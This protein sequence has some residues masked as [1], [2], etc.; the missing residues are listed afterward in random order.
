[1]FVGDAVLSFLPFV[2]VRI[3]VTVP[4]YVLPAQYA[5]AYVSF[6]L[7]SFHFWSLAFFFSFSSKNYISSE[8]LKKN[9]KAVELLEI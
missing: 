1:V 5:V 4:S 7:T 9:Y 2:V 6:L 3:C 8:A